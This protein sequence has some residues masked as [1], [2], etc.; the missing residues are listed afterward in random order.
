MNKGG[1]IP[2]NSM[3]QKPAN[4]RARDFAVK[5]MSTDVS[6]CQAQQTTRAQVDMVLPAQAHDPASARE[7]GQMSGAAFVETAT[8]LIYA[9]WDWLWANIRP[10]IAVLIFFIV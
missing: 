2:P 9:A 1:V 7:L 5:R 3:V 6:S 4:R 10:V 8:E